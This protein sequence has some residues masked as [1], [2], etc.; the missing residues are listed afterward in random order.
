MIAALCLLAGLFSL[1]ALPPAVR[2][3]TDY[4][5]PAVNKSIPAVNGQRLAD[6][7]VVVVL[8]GVSNA[9]LDAPGD[10]WRFV[11]LRRRAGEGAYGTVQAVQ[12]SG[13]APTW[14][15][16]L[17]G[18]GPAVSGVVDRSSSRPL[19]VPTLFDLARRAGKRS[20]VV[21]SRVAWQGRAVIATPDRIMLAASSSVVADQAVAL[22]RGRSEE[23]VMVLLDAG[24]VLGAAPGERWARV[25]RQFAAIVAALDPAHDTLIATAD[26]GF[27]ADGSSGG[28]EQ[29]AVAVPL[30]L[31]GR[32]I[33][34]TAIGSVDQ[35]DIAPTVSALLGLAY[36]PYGGTPLLDALRL[37]PAQRAAEL[38]RLLD[39]KV[40]S[41]GS[42]AAS[43]PT[44]DAARALAT[45]RSLYERQDWNGA[46]DE[47]RRGLVALAQTPPLPWFW[48]SAW[49]WG[50][51]VPLLLLGLG[52]LAGRFRRELLRMLLPFAGLGAYLL[53]WSSIYF[54]LAGK[55]LSLSAIYGGWS[56]N[57]L[58]IGFWSALALLVV[59]GGMGFAR[60][61]GGALIAAVELGLAALLIVGSLAG[62][63][64]AYVFVTGLPG[65]RIPDLTGW[66]LL[67]V[68][69]VLAAGAGLAT[70]FGMLVA[71]AV[72]EIGSRGR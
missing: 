11:Q 13:D 26:H 4:H 32:A 61:R 10:P 23:L 17:S 51:I 1:L 54:L 55:P 43:A 57:L 34:G 19:S 65:S 42:T 40:S 52:R 70:P 69:L 28:D 15:T 49:V 50:G 7:V 6:R 46:A 67:L 68:A 16:L 44:V 35:R 53:V 21:M 36:S 64:V 18:A 33:N 8:S 48:T 2:V 31:W 56:T 47:A 29:Q 3:L 45:A 41:A 38:I 22:L 58:M 37:T 39:I 63:A 60:M 30:V 62:F 25:D 12:P 72:G 24:R 59:A 66:T 27:L 9:D 14:A 71:A 20:A 5:A